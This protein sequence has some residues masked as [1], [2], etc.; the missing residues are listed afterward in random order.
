[1]TTRAPKTRT[2]PVP[3]PAE[4]DGVLRISTSSNP[5]VEEAREVLFVIDDEEFTVPKV[6]DQRIVYLGVDAIRESGPIFSGQRIV[7]LLLGK[8]QYNRLL[9]HY[10]RQAITQDNFDAIVT[11]VSKLFFDHMNRD[12]DA[13]GKATPAS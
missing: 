8:P 4:A 5:P 2:A 3:T 6:I 11:I 7:E 1:M 10:E 12:D 9:E 13:A